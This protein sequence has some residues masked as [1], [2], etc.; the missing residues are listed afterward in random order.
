MTS[1]IAEFLSASICVHP[2][3]IGLFYVTGFICG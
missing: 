3:E 2:V 1:G